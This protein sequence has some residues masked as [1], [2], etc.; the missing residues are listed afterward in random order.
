MIL[1]ARKN[2]VY[3][4]EGYK[5]RK[6][7]VLEGVSR[8]GEISTKGLVAH[9]EDWEG[10]IAAD[11]APN[12]LRLIRDPDGHIRMMTLRE[13]IDRAHFIKG[14]GPRGVRKL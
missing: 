5:Q 14:H 13:Q 3:L 4:P 1:V 6:N 2:V 7:K 9:T 10:R 11:I 8:K 12:A